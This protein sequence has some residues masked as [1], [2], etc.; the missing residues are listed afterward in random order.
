[1]EPRQQIK[2]PETLQTVSGN[3]LLSDHARSYTATAAH[4]LS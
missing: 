4:A 3:Y 1:M 2:A